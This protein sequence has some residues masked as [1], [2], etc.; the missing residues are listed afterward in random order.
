VY[1]DIVSFTTIS[2]ACT[3]NEVVALLSELYSRFDRL[4][5]IND[6]YKVQ[7]STGTSSLHCLQVETVGDAYI[8]VAGVPEEASRH[9]EM[10]L[11][12]AIGMQW[13]VRLVMKPDHSEPLRVCATGGLVESQFVRQIRAGVH[14]GPIVAGV[15]GRKMPRYCLFGDTPNIAG[16]MEARGRP[17]RIHVSQA[18]HKLAALCPN[19]AVPRGLDACVRRTRTCLNSSTMNS[20]S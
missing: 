3:P 20:L 12:M 13:E 19:H 14:T 9:A 18:T 10:V 1:T 6:L 16:Q 7:Q 5:T 17:T 4:V 15:V 11:N 2:A 8:A